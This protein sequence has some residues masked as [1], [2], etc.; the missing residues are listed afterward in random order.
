MAALPEVTIRPDAPHDAD[1]TTD[2]EDASWCAGYVQ[3]IPA[4]ASHTTDFDVSGR[5]FSTGWQ[6]APGQGLAVATVPDP[7]RGRAAGFAWFTRARERARGFAGR[8]RELSALHLHPDVWGSRI[9]APRIAHPQARRLADGC[10]E[11][12]PSALDDSH[13]TRRFDDGDGSVPTGQGATFAVAGADADAEV[14]HP[15]RLHRTE[16]TA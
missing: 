8:R 1:G 2:I 3:A 4:C 12:A 9:A 14:E 5:R 11:A 15:R 6:L 7:E 10:F 16:R 13:R